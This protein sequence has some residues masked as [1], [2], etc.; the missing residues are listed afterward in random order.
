MKLAQAKYKDHNGHDIEA[1]AVS[2]ITSYK[3]IVDG[4]Y[5]WDCGYQECGFPHS[6][7][8]C[9]WPIAGQVL[10]CEK[11]KRM[12]LLLRSDCEV[13]GEAVEKLFESESLRREIASL[14]D[15]RKYNDDQL[16]KIRCE[17]I[18]T[19]QNSLTDTI[20]KLPVP[21]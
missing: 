8:S 5:S 20:G 10:Q 7:R 19:L 21:K 1:S 6:S 2:V 14:R 18:G 16:Y 13:I 4:F 3:H 11:C 12:N 15:I 17:L 9:G